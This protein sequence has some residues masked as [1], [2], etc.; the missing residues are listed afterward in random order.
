MVVGQPVFGGSAQAQAVDGVVGAQT[1]DRWAYPVVQ[2]RRVEEDT[3]A[4]GWCVYLMGWVICLCCP[5]GC[6]PLFWLTLACTY[7]TKPREE[8]D[9]LPK[10]RR[11]AQVSLLTA[12]VTTVLAVVFVI[13]ATTTSA[14]G[15]DSRAHTWI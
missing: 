12:V 6:G 4:S 14:S 13:W 9:A 7:W 10:E 8:R 1:A 5:L 11:I 2:M 15:G 3:G